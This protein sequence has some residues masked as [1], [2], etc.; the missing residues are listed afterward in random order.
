MVDISYLLSR[1]IKTKKKNTKFTSLYTQ[2]HRL[3]FYLLF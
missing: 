3:L 2:M 1:Y